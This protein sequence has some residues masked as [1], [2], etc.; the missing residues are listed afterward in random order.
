LGVPIVYLEDDPIDKRYDFIISSD[1][2]DSV[3]PNNK[4]DT[5]HS[6]IGSLKQNKNFTVRD[7]DNI[8]NSHIQKL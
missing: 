1:K 8:F 3:F 4:K 2:I 5:I 6:V 7:N